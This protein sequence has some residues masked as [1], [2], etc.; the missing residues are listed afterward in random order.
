MPNPSAR[1]SIYSRSSDFI[2][3]LKGKAVGAV[4]ARGAS[5]AIVVRITGTTMAFGVQVLLA[6]DVGVVEFG[7]YVYALS[8][9]NV[10]TM[11]SAFGLDT[12]SLRFVAQ[13]HAPENW[14]LWR[15]FLQRSRSSVWVGATS[16]G[17]LAA[18]LVYVLQSRL[19]H[20][21]TLT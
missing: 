20:G 1:H 7:I 15:G 9:P 17:V 18:A 16:M 13:Y 14:E 10:L 6:R 12:A 8:W 19:G 2:L 5:T 4:L 3:Q 21:Q 11:V